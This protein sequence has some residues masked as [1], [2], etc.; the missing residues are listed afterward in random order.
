LL[1]FERTLR[2]A[3][4]SRDGLRRL[5]LMQPYGEEGKLM[6]LDYVPERA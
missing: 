3:Q 4:R 2:A 6:M 1:A 5:A